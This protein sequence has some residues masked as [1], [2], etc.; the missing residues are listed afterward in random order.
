ME[1]KGKPHNADTYKAF[2]AEIGYLV[3]DGGNSQVSTENVDPEIDV[4]AGAHHVVPVTNARWGSLYVAPY[5]SDVSS[6]DGGATRT[7]AHKSVRG[8]KVIAFSAGFLDEAAPL[9]DRN[10]ADAIGKDHTAG[11]KDVVLEAAITTIQDLVDSISAVDAEDKALAYSNLYGLMKGD[12]EDAFKMGGSTMTRRLAPDR[13]YA[14][15][16]GSSL[17]LP[18]RSLLLIRNLGQHIYTDAVTVDGA[19]VPEGFLD[20]TMTGLIC[21]HDLKGNGKYRNSRT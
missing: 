20:A 21:I 9:A 10:H 13:D 19:E 2:L 14:A 3:P 1:R 4:N 18:G 16:N 8:E 12:L 15:P 7:G 17:T 11:V 5:C 6:E